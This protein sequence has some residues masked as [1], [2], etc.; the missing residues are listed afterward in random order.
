MSLSQKNTISQ[1]SNWQLQLTLH[2]NTHVYYFTGIL[3]NDNYIDNFHISTIGKKQKLMSR[4]LTVS[5]MLYLLYNPTSKLLNPSVR[6]F[7]H[8]ISTFTRIGYVRS[9]VL[10]WYHIIYHPHSKKVSTKRIKILDTSP[11]GKEPI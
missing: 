9:N 5:D 6:N 2:N 8:T 1:L 11:P 3:Q 7:S 10:Y 4:L